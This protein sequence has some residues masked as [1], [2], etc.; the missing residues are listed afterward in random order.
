MR[1]KLGAAII[2]A[3]LMVKGVAAKPEGALSPAEAAALF[4]EARPHIEAVMGYR[5][6]PP[7]RFRMANERDLEKWR[8]AEVEAEISWQFPDVAKAGGRAL[9]ETATEARRGRLSACI[10]GASGGKEIILF[11][12]NTAK[13]AAWSA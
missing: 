11:P 9:V 13:I 4:A 3:G 2:A 1:A 8:R 6:D 10:A 7:P 12:G 5:F